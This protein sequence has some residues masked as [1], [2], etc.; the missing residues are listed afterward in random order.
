LAG[1]AQARQQRG[2]GAVLDAGGRAGRDSLSEAPPLVIE[3]QFYPIPFRSI[4]ESSVLQG[5]PSPRPHAA[6]A[7]RY[8]SSIQPAVSHPARAVKEDSQDSCGCDIFCKDSCRAVSCRV[9]PCRVVYRQ[10]PLS[11]AWLCS[12]VAVCSDPHVATVRIV[13]TYAQQPERLVRRRAP[14]RLSAD[15]CHDDVV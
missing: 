11:F 4:T 10:R 1:A 14:R 12:Y 2:G 13:S 8:L 3:P 9:V 5:R 7:P 6:A 15:V